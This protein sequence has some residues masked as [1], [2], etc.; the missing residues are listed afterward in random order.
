MNFKTLYLC[1][2]GKAVTCGKQGCHANGGPCYLTTDS[3]HAEEKGGEKIVAVTKE[4]QI[5][6]YMKGEDLGEQ[7]EIG[8]KAAI[9]RFNRANDY[10]RS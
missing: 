5:Y 6:A 2:P 3:D 4:D 1:D 8:T 9:A 7:A 10:R